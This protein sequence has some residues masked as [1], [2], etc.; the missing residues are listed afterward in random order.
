MAASLYI[1]GAKSCGKTLLSFGLIEKFRE[2]N[3]RASYFK[4]VSM[5]IKDKSGKIVDSDV[6]L[7]KEALSLENPVE[8]VSPVVHCICGRIFHHIEPED[9]EKGITKAYETIKRGND[10]VVIEGSQ[11]SEY[12]GF[13]ASKLSALLNSRV[14]FVVRGGENQIVETTLRNRELFDDDKAR[15]MGIIINSVPPDQIERIRET[16]IPALQRYE[17]RVYGVI[18]EKRELI[19]TVGDIAEALN[20]ETLSGEEYLD[21]FIG[22]LLV[23]NMKSETGLIHWFRRSLN[24]TMMRGGDKTELILEALEA[25]LGVLITSSNSRP[26]DRVVTKSSEKK[27]PILSTPLDELTAMTRVGEV[28]DVVTPVFLRNKGRIIKEMVE[29]HVDW[30]EILNITLDKQSLR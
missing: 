7:L 5:G 9:A 12:Y 24:Q 3:L 23:T 26:T 17:V 4:P 13:N 19:A 20:A 10:V 30:K 6:S 14:I 8:E 29:E 16:I 21:R 18:P 28:T 11:V 15:F 22:D 2:R 1:D 25:N 27:V